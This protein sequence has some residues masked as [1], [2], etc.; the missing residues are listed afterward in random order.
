[1]LFPPTVVVLSVAHF[2]GEVWSASKAANDTVARYTPRLL[3][4]DTAYRDVVRRKPVL[5]AVSLLTADG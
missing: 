5:S 3:R 2:Q 4:R 1:M